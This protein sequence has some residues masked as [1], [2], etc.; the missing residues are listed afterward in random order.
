MSGWAGTL[1]CYRPD[2][3]GGRLNALVNALRL[4]ALTGAALKVHW[5]QDPGIGRAINDPSELFAAGFIER[6]FIE[7]DSWRVAEKRSAWLIYFGTVTA[8]ALKQHLWQGRD[9]L[10][11]HAVGAT[12]LAGEKGA[13]VRRELAR[14][15]QDL[16]LSPAVAACADALRAQIGEGTVCYHIRRGDILTVPQEINRPWPAKF[17]VDEVFETHLAREI[18]RGLRPILFSDD[19]ATLDRFASRFPGVVAA[20]QIIGALGP[21]TPGQ[22]DMVELIAMSLCARIIAPQS[23]AF[24]SVAAMLGGRKRVDVTADLTEEERALAQS[25]LCTRLTAA[26]P[27]RARA[28]PGDIGQSLWH[29]DG[30]LRRTGEVPALRQAVEAQVAAGLDVSFVY[31]MLMGLQLETGDPAA[32]I[33][34]RDRAVRNI[35]HYAVD[36]ARCD[37]LGAVAHALRNQADRAASLALRAHWH[38]AVTDPKPL[39]PGTPEIAEIS[40]LLLEGGVLGAHNFLPASPVAERLARV[41]LT[42]LQAPAYGPLRAR[43]LAQHQPPM[44]LRAL[45]PMDWDWRVMMRGNSAQRFATDAAR[46]AAYGFL[47]TEVQFDPSPDAL[48][49]LA[50]HDALMG[51]AAPALDRIAALAERSPRDATLQ[52]RL[53]VVALLARKPSAAR[54]AAQTALAAAG[55]IPAH[56]AWAGRLEVRNGDAAAGHRMLQEVVAEGWDIPPLRLVM[57]EAA[58]KLDR[59]D[60]QIA[61]IE[62]ALAIAPHF[63]DALLYR[64]RFRAACGDVAAARADLDRIKAQVPDHRKAAELRAQLDGAA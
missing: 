44:T 2:R 26:E 46:A 52:H 32:A 29:L 11:N 28:M 60:Q 59:P 40:A 3:L 23:S 1:Y 33:A 8:A 61:A 35:P 24:S 13:A 57:A 21:L 53:S 45:A 43:F 37:A 6:Y 18:D 64:A 16:P 7:D 4:A 49:L 22:Q 42:A 51:D 55:P 62:A 39:D 56:R 25:R 63:P 12:V 31:P 50:L 48:S 19:P 54:A 5:Y 10:V 20:P 30:M 14:I 27:A 38:D 15:W 17:T 47:I 9:L 34:T 58:A 36:L 41:P